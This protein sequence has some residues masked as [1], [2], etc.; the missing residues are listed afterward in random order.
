MDNL[1]AIIL[2]AGKG[3]RMNAKKINKV[4]V[5]VGGQPIIARTIQTLKSAGI[6]N[7]VVVVGHAKKSVIDLLDKD[8]SWVEQKKRIGTAH[9]V[10]VVLKSIPKDVQDLL[11]LYGDDSYLY[12]PDIFLMLYQLH[13]QKA[14]SV[15][16]LS[17][18]L[19]NP[20]GLGRVLKD[21]QGEVMDVI[22]EKD[23]TNEQK[24]IK[25]VNLG[26]FLFDLN[27]LRKNINKLQKSK[28]TGEYYITDI[29]KEA[30]KQK[31]KVMVLKLEAQ[32]WRGINTPEE[33]KEAQGLIN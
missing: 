23:A 10:K 8:V 22:E 26:G 31:A 19:A 17:T 13:Q 28:V 20:F 1:W 11:V 3:K 29:I 21:S 2:A 25:E 7:T 16:F 27:F 9:A 12:T 32:K 14:A 33:L 18:E 6:K 5:T 15:S 30:V 24:K 4:T